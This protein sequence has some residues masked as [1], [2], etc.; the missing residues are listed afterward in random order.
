M[1][2]D[3]VATPPAS[4]NSSFHRLDDENDVIREELVD[5]LVTTDN[6]GTVVK[7]E[8]LNAFK[9][10][11]EYKEIFSEALEKLSKAVAFRVKEASAEDDEVG[12][13]NNLEDFWYGGEK[14][15]SCQP[16]VKYKNSE[17]VPAAIRCD[18]KGSFGFISKDQLK[19]KMLRSIAKHEKSDLHKWC[20]VEAEK[21]LKERLDERE[22]NLKI[23]E[24]IVRNAVFCLKKG[25]SPRDFI[26]LNEKDGLTEELE[27][28]TKNDSR[29]EFKRIRNYV[30]EEIDFKIKDIIKN[31]D[32]I[33]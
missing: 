16:C 20:V 4:Q 10:D 27:V 3:V 21:G 12:Q 5:N 32:K 24:K 6:V 22:R 33:K 8:L 1:M 2:L 19:R 13:L 9:G 11:G 31:R 7:R 28:A 30:K 23:G 26:G 18:K 25:M 14:F 29:K 15:L 17:N